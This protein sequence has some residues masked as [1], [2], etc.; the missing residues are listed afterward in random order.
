MQPD[1]PKIAKAFDGR[2]ISFRERKII[3]ENSSTNYTLYCTGYKNQWG[4][5]DYHLELV[6][7]MPNSRIPKLVTEFFTDESSLEDTVRAVLG[8]H[9]TGKFGLAK[10]EPSQGEN[11]N[12]GHL[13]WHST[14]QAFL[15]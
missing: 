6:S 13:I 15:H 14:A 1:M 3:K 8:R 11:S 12:Y 4:E 7:D 10:I 5:T 2:I 9:F